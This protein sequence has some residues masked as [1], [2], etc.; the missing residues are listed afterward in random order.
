MP[1][2]GCV[3][4]TCEATVG[5]GAFHPLHPKIVV[6]SYSQSDAIQGFEF[7]DIESRKLLDR[8]EGVSV[9]RLMFSS[10]GTD[11]FVTGKDGLLRFPI[12]VETDDSENILFPNEPT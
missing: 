1:P 10:D 3:P 4:Q 12:R 5:E 6:Q 2:F 11:L 8:I 7:W 9:R